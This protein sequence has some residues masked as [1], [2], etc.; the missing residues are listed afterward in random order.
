[1][2]QP[3]VPTCIEEDELAAELKKELDK[4]GLSY[5]EAHLGKIATMMSE[6]ATFPQDCSPRADSYSKLQPST[7]RKLAI[8]SGKTI[9]LA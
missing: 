3:T 1:M 8:K 4:E 2:V 5:N 6:R 7:T 9:V